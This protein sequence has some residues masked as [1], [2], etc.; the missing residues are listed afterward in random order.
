MSRIEHAA[1]YVADLETARLF[2]ETYLGASSN[3]GYHNETTGFRSY[4]LT[5]EDGARLEL[6]HRPQMDDFP[7]M[8]H[9]ECV[10]LMSR[11]K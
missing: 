11:E 6:M 1:L 4:F 7:K 9:V 10:V 5:F 3:G 2:F 8:P